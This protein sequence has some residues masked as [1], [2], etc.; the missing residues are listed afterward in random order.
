MSMMLMSNRLQI[1]HL[2]SQGRIEVLEK[3]VAHQSTANVK[4]SSDMNKSLA[5]TN[6]KLKMELGNLRA[7]MDK[8][9]KQHEAANKE[10][11]ELTNR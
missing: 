3:K 5:D 1:P 10:R 11:N 8:L 2:L 7:D 9:G 4:P 6:M